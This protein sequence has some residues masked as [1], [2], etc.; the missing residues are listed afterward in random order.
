MG[1]KHRWAPL[2]KKITITSLFRLKK[3]FKSNDYFATRYRP[4]Q[5]NNDYFI[6]RYL[7]PQKSI[8]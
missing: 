4:T 6:T 7:P 5:K 1:N 2:L 3:S 8:D